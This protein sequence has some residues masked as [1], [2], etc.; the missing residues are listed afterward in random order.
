MALILSQASRLPDATRFSGV[1]APFFLGHLIIPEPFCHLIPT[2]FSSQPLRPRGN[3][4]VKGVVV[5]QIGE[6]SMSVSS[7]KAS[8]KLSDK[9]IMHPS[10]SLTQYQ[11]FWGNY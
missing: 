1:L 6:V 9:L 2:H 5:A 11:R 4:R 3:I 7:R 8:L 10:F